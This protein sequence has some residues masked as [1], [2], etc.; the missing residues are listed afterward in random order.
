V[1]RLG[2]MPEPDKWSNLAPVWNLFDH[3]PGKRYRT[4]DG[5]EAVAL[6]IGPEGQLMCSIDGETSSIMAAEAMFGR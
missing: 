6:G 5:R 4:V 3:T 1:E 2:K